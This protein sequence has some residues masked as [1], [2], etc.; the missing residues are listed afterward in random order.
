MHF[1]IAP[2]M[3]Q[4]DQFTL[5]MPFFCQMK[6]APGEWK[7]PLENIFWY[8]LAQESKIYPMFRRFKNMK[9]LYKSM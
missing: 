4:I 5:E 8:S 7:G 3:L 1:L 6:G 2:K 9:L